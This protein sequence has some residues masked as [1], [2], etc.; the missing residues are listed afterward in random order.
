[1]GTKVVQATQ[2]SG[3]VASLGTM[4][5]SL[6]IAYAARNGLI[7]AQ[8]AKMALPLTIES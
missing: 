5:K 7:A 6:N 3:L 2:S 4:A 8:L 1:M